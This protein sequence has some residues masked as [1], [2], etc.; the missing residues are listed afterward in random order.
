MGL[1][2]L[3]CNPTCTLDAVGDPLPV[4]LIRLS[5]DEAWVWVL[6]YF[7]KEL[8]GDS[9]AQQ[10]ETCPRG[11]QEGPEDLV[12]SSRVMGITVLVVFKLCPQF[13]EVHQ[14]PLG[15]GV[16]MGQVGSLLDLHTIHTPM[17]RDT[18]ALPALQRS[19]PF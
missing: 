14:E 8:L 2:L 10:G 13:P 17:I 1:A 16:R 9:N 6:V 3:D 11:F 4:R 19:F 7:F 18:P 5:G 15:R 12:S